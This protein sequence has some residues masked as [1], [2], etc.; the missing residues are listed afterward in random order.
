MEWTYDSLQNC[1]EV[2]RRTLMLQVVLLSARQGCM[3]NTFHRVLPQLQV[4]THHH[5]N[6]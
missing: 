3:L 5:E 6:N 1:D 2:H 4:R